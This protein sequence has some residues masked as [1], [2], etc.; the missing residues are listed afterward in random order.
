MKDM[1]KCDLCIDS[2]G[3][4]P[5]CRKCLRDR[6]KR[7]EHAESQYENSGGHDERY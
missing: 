3:V 5:P 6:R 2:S 1:D 7:R 4:E